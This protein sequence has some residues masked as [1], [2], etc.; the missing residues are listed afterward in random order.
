MKILWFLLLAQWSSDP[1]Q[2]TPVIQWPEDQKG[3]QVV[4]D[5]HG[6]ALIFWYDRRNGNDWDLYGQR[7][8]SL[9]YPLWGAGGLPIVTF[10]GHQYGHKAVPD[11]NG[12]AF[13]VWQD[14]RNGEWDLFAQH[15]SPDGVLL[16]DSTGVPVCTAPGDQ[17]YPDLLPDGSGGLFVVWEDK[18]TGTHSDIYGQRISAEGTPLWEPDGV[19]ICIAANPQRRP[20]IAPAPGG[21]L[22]VV[23]YDYRA[24]LLAADVYLQRL[25]GEGTPLWQ[26]NGIPI[27]SGPADDRN[28]RIIPDETRGVIVIWENGDLYGQRI[29]ST[30]AF[31]W[32]TPGVLICGA[33]G[34]QWGARV[35][36][37]GAGG[38]LLAWV[39]ERLGLLETDIYAQR[40]SSEGV[41]LWV[42]NGVP[43]TSAPGVQ[44]NLEIASDDSGGLFVIWQDNRNGAT[45]PEIYAQRVDSAGTVRWDPNGIAVSIAPLPQTFPTLASDGQGNFIAAWEDR[46]EDTHWDIYA[47]RVRGD[48]TL[49]GPYPVTEVSSTRVLPIRILIQK[50]EVQISLTLSYRTWIRLALFTPAGRRVT[51]IFSGT[52]PSGTYRFS[53]NLPHPGVY[54]LLVETWQTKLSHK[55]LIFP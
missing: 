17:E 51:H 30:G 10:N 11:G 33:D 24:T 35:L 22:Y 48:G 39:D 3:A 37:D 23:W 50:T 28:P 14:T 42:S 12:G 45:N 16:W 1:A 26:E 27:T 2:N 8:D 38:L 21:G 9:G 52:L 43:L 19:P 5:Q 29:D 32:P 44:L 53:E 4:S 49:G 20:K 54:L 41:P 46:R 36:P 6:G 25:D 15:I 34:N 13:V 31:L 7:L 40:L 18:R 55:L 47:Q